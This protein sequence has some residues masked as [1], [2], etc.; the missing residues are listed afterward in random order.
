LAK[1]LALI[2]ESCKIVSGRSSPSPSPPRVRPMLSYLANSPT[3]LPR[4]ARAP[5][6]PGIEE[7]LEEEKEEDEGAGSKSNPILVTRRMKERPTTVM[8]MRVEDRS[9]EKR[10]KSSRRQSGLLSGST[11]GEP[12]V[13]R[14]GSPVPGGSPMQREAG[15]ALKHEEDQEEDIVTMSS[16]I[17]LDRVRK[18]N[19]DLGHAEVN[20]DLSSKG[21]EKEVEMERQFQERRSKARDVGLDFGTESNSSELRDRQHRD[22][23]NV[24]GDDDYALSGRSGLD[25]THHKTL[26]DVTNSPRSRPADA[27][28][29]SP[30][31]P[32]S[33]QSS[34]CAG[35]QF[36]QTRKDKGHPTQIMIVCQLYL[37]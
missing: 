21:K 22:A 12:P 2:R 9:K 36:V 37:E 26:K 16:T 11:R 7:A 18:A 31:L 13:P 33:S 17:L 20:S 30:G 8:P 25:A 32:S 15:L 14:A 1:H 29:T 5:D 19:G 10:K 34:T 27:A 24:L 35:D 4:L 23:T 6:I 3:Q 28:I